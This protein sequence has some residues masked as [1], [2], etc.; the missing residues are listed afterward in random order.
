MRDAT[1]R[2]LFV[3]DEP[4][5]LE[6][7]ENL[8]FDAP[9]EWEIHFAQSGEEALRL[10]AS[11]PFDVL[12]TDM[13]M[14]EMDGAALLARARAAFPTVVRIV[15]SGHTEAEAAQR[16]MPLAHEFLSKPCEP[17]VL[18]DAL[19]RAL[20]LTRRFTDGALR[21]ALGTVGSLPARPET[22]ARVDRA[23]TEGASLERVAELLEHDLA[24]ATKVLHV[25]NTAFYSRLRRVTSLEDAVRVLGLATTRA[26]VLGVETLESFRVPAWLDLDAMHAHALEVGAL[27]ARLAPTDHRAEALLGGL[28]H[29]V[30]ELLIATYFAEAGQRA[31]E[32]QRREKIHRGEA[33]L[34][35]LGFDHA[36]IGGYLMRLWHLSSEVASAV[37]RH[38][39]AGLEDRGVVELA[40]FAA[41]WAHHARDDSVLTA[42]ELR[43]V[44]RARELSRRE[45]A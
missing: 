11:A 1:S 34:R 29:D 16:A 4:R 38:H 45:A 8:L 20:V 2:L 27:A 6:G 33:E 42:R 21:R 35:V 5:V 17:E 36:D 43:A 24:V 12:V 26:V 39:R 10:L 41:D 28:L 23:I 13:R 22:F 30:G 31:A 3:D 40:V 37:E 44:E 9:D 32:L 15:L 14:P 25:A 18:I 19:D 7:L